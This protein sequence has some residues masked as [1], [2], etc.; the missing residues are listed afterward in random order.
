MLPLESLDTWPD[1]CQCDGGIWQ[2][3]TTLVD[4]RGRESLAV[5]KVKAPTDEDQ[6]ADGSAHPELVH[7]NQVADQYT[8]AST[9]SLV[10]A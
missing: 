2:L 6:L 9:C 1:S 5:T 8:A 10:R 3:I 4:S 7:G